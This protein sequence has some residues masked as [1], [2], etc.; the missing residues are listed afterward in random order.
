MNQESIFSTESSS[1]PYCEAGECNEND[2][3]CQEMTCPA[4]STDFA[5]IKHE[6]EMISETMELQDQMEEYK[7]GNDNSIESSNQSLLTCPRC[8]CSM[9]FHNLTEDSFILMCD[10]P[11]M[12]SLSTLNLP[13]DRP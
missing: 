5:T 10:S 4:D 9:K 3:N 8:N 11:N 1:F 13:N 6:E 2:N 12:V 7:E